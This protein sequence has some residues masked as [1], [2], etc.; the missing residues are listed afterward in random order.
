MKERQFPGIGESYFEEQLANGLRLRIVPKKD[1]A[2]KYAF[3]AVDFGSIDT[4]FS[5]GRKEYCVPAGIA[6]Y[7]EHKMFDLPGEDAMNLFARYGGSPNAF[8][9][10]DMTAYYVSCTE[11]FEE[12]LKILLRM[13]MTPWFTEESVEKERGI[14]AQEIRMYEDSV[15]S[16]VGEDLFRILFS[17]HPIRVPIAGSVE[18]IGEI[19]AQMLHDCYSAFYRPGNMMLCVVGD[20]D[21]QQVVRIA[22][23]NTPDASGELPLRDYGGEESLLPNRSR[24]V[25]QMEASMPTFAIG[26]AC[27]PHGDTA[28]CM[29]REIVGDIAAEILV[30][31]SSPLYQRLY[32]EGLIDGDFSAGYESVKNACL[33]SAGGNSRDPEAVLE[34]ILKEAERLCAEGFDRKL[35]HRLKKSALG[36]RTR[37]LDSFES[38]CYRNCA[39]QFDGVDYFSFPDAYADVTAEDVEQFL[40]ETVRKEKAAMAVVEPKKKED[41]HEI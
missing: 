9:S 41:A 40:R 21:A 39:Y 30:G 37:D 23:E 25:R 17:H 6:H 1:F 11:C 34:A 3:L 18:S 20:V 31:E 13:V 29:R 27:P 12:N 5:L 36:R 16:R 14:I 33:L 7:L 19:T 24:S 4:N 2:K 22:W 28:L 15:H 38:I 32:E 26:F 35:F 10:Y 8:T